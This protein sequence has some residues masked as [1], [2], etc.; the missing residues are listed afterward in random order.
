MTFEG[1]TAF[2]TGGAA[3]FGR[4]FADALSER[5]AS[6]ALADID[7]SVAETAAGELRDK[8]RGAIAVGCDVADLPQTLV[9]DMV[10]TRQLIHR[11]GEPDDIVAALLFLCAP[12]ARHVTGETLK[13]CGGYPLV[14]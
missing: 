11:V 10:N 2:I 13:V 12:D 5:G 3:G 14:I 9:D 1:A 7:V 6:V 4:A 8:G